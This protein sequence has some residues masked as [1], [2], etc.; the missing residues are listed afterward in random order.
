MPVSPLNS[1]ATG[2]PLA[3]TGATAATRYVGATTSGAPASGTFA[4]GDFIIDQSGQVYVCTAAGSPGTWTAIGAGITLIA[5]QSGAQATFDFQSIP[6]TYTHLRIEVIARC[7]NA[8]SQNLLIRFNNDSA[9]N[10]DSHSVQGSNNT[11]AGSA[12]AGGTSGF[13]GS[14]PGTGDGATRVGMSVIEI[15]F[16]TETTFFQSWCTT[17]GRSTGTTAATQ[18][19]QAM[20]GNWRDAS[21]VSRVTLLP[22]AGSFVAGSVAKLYG[23]A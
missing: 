7:D 1:R 16:Y 5:T 14:V 12:S 21:A 3:L 11:V 23:I 20:F 22:G 13:A 15:P 6:Q 19:M 2:L 18:F 8:A 17:G 4:V 9:A 10:Y